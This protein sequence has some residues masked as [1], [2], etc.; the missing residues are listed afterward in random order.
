MNRRRD[1]TT[2]SY[3]MEWYRNYL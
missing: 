1:K 3:M 2:N